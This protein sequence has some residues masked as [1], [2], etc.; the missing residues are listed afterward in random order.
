MKP[1]ATLHE[2]VKNLGVTGIHSPKGKP[3]KHNTA[4]WNSAE[5]LKGE[6]THGKKAD[7]KNNL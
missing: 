1:H 2:A 5:T 6:P 4:V 7:N 3:C